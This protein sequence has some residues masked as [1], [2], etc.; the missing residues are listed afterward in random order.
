MVSV[1]L[2]AYGI[3]GDVLGRG[4][5]NV[6]QSES[7]LQQL[8]TPFRTEPD[9]LRKEEEMCLVLDKSGPQS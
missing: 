4:T 8:S 9:G 5:E 3:V 6:L 2:Q 1:F 7:E